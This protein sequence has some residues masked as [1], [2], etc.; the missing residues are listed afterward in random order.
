M[1]YPK[2]CVNAV[3]SQ[4]RMLV[5]VLNIYGRHY[6]V[7]VVVVLTVW[8]MLHLMYDNLDAA[9]ATSF[10]LSNLKRIVF[11]FNLLVYAWEVALNLQQ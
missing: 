10:Y 2:V 7:L 6:L 4:L 5:D 8:H 3:K 1:F 11:V 9:N